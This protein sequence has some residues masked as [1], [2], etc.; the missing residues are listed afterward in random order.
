MLVI[1]YIKR[2]SRTGKV[3]EC[4]AACFASWFVVRNAGAPLFSVIYSLY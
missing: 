2:V 4:G 1:D 3:V